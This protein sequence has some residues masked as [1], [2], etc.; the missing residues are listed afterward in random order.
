MSIWSSDPD[1]LNIRDTQDL[2]FIYARLERLRNDNPS[3]DVAQIKELVDRNVATFLDAILL[4]EFNYDEWVRRLHEPPDSDPE[5]QEHRMRELL[6]DLDRAE[7]FCWFLARFPTHGT[8]ALRVQ[9]WQRYTQPLAAVAN[10]DVAMHQDKFMCLH[11]EVEDTVRLFM[12]D[13]DV[14]EPC[15]RAMRASKVKYIMLHNTFMSR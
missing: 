11:D 9:D 6:A 1:D 14:T 3:K 7:L 4:Y 5:E 12:S 2:A 8:H 13:G 15:A 10:F